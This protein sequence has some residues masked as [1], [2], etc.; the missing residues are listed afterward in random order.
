MAKNPPIKTSPRVG[1]DFGFNFGIPRPWGLARILPPGDLLH[2]DLT[3]RGDFV[4]FSRWGESRQ[5]KTLVII[6]FLLITSSHWKGL[7]HLFTPVF[8]DSKFNFSF[9]NSQILS[10]F[11]LKFEII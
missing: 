2:P 8:V 10:N 1:T 11:T 6:K 7:E 5:G 4:G 3:S 9:F